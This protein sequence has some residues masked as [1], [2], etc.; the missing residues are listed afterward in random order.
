LQLDITYEDNTI[1]SIVS[2]SSW[3]TLDGPIVY[4]EVR[5]GEIYD[6]RLAVEGWMEPC[7]DDSEWQNVFVSR[8]AGGILKRTDIPPIRVTATLQATRISDVVYDVGQNVSGWVK[9][10]TNGKVRWSANTANSDSAPIEICNSVLIDKSK[11]MNQKKD[12]GVW[13]YI[14]TYKLS[15]GSG[16]YVKLLAD[17]DG[18][19]IADAV[20]FEPIDTIAFND[21]FENGISKWTTVKGTWNIVDD[22]SKVYKQSGDLGESIIT[23]GSSNWTDYF[24][25]AD[26]RLYAVNQSV[27]LLGRYIDNENYYMLRLNKT[28][29]KVELYKK[30][31]DKLKLISSAPFAVNVGT[32]YKLKLDMHGNSLTGYVD[33]VKK[34]EAIDSSISNGRVGIRGTHGIGVAVNRLALIM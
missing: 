11:N 17:D 23:A 9:I 25:E 33:G 29:G 8:G 27:G 4:N 13:N 5:C 14:G 28:D 10:K 32:N 19:T 34:I 7:F 20:R 22:N 26:L 12:G 21:D 31:K 1:E 3:K 15:S 18:Y 16:N 2:D 30:E 24:V 6:A